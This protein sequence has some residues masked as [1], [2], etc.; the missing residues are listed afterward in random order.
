M[1]NEIEKKA[2]F[3]LLLPRIFYSTYLTVSFSMHNFSNRSILLSYFLFPDFWFRIFP[4][5]KR[6][7]SRFNRREIR[8]TK[9]GKVSRRENSS[10]P[11][12]RPQKVVDNRQQSRL[13]TDLFSFLDSCFPCLV[14]RVAALW[15]WHLT[16]RR[17]LFEPHTAILFSSRDTRSTK[18]DP[19]K[20]REKEER[21]EEERTCNN[22]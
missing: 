12:P 17:F 11:S 7:F 14:T 13:K 4:R 8:I 18:K 6:K 10:L 19:D 2:L 9:I 22:A 5:R 15:G 3:R 20:R 16:T 21:A 1:L